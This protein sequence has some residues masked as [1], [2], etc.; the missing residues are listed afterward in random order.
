MP[1]SNMMGTHSVF[2]ICE[3]SM[4]LSRIVTLAELARVG[5]Q[6]LQDLAQG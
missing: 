4:G 2:A 3:M 1:P 5:K 6:L